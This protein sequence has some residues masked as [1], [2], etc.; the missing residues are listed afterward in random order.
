[1]ALAAACALLAVGCSPL[2]DDTFVGQPLI[3]LHG[4]FTNDDTPIEVANEIGLLWQDPGGTIGP[5]FAVTPLPY[6]TSLGTF[7]TSVPIEPPPNTYETFADH[8][9][10]IAEAYIHVVVAAPIENT[11]YDLGQD[12]THVL[13]YAKED[14]DDGDAADYLG[15][16]VP[17]GYHLRTFT[18]TT[19][20][21]EAQQ[22]LIE[23][24][25]DDTGDIASCTA[26][27]EYQL[28]PAFDGAL[29]DVM[30]TAR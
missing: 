5:G 15:G 20:P 16:P 22:Q 9:P 14:V 21:G 8:G 28:G 13:I 2:A 4:Q 6:V 3:T 27:R 25:I 11:Q 10:G 19:M 1:M 24:C 30:V 7:K 17:A 23:H 12:Q 26:R 29:L 18:A